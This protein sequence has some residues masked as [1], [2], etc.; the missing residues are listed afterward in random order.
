[1]HL[2]CLPQNIHGV[3]E[4]VVVSPSFHSPK[5][6]SKPQNKIH[7]QSSRGHI[8]NNVTQQRHSWLCPYIDTMLI[9]YFPKDHPSKASNQTPYTLKSPNYLFYFDPSHGLTEEGFKHPF[10]SSKISFELLLWLSFKYLMSE[11][12]LSV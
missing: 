6:W 4:I 11:Y 10:I 9:K 8:Q 5:K 2:S 7:F 3:F 12:F 1:M